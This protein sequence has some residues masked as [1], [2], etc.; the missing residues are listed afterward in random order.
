M[1][2]NIISLVSDW[3]ENGDRVKI[4]RFSA[5]IKGQFTELMFNESVDPIPSEEYLFHLRT[6]D[7]KNLIACLQKKKEQFKPLF[8]KILTSTLKMTKH[9]LPKTDLLYSLQQ[10]TNKTMA[11][12]DEH[13]QTVLIISDGLENSDYLRFHG[14]GDVKKVRLKR[15]IKKLKK[16][17]LIAKWNHADIYMYGLG[18]ISNTNAYIRPKLMEPLKKFWKV[19]F[20]EG[21]GKVKQLGTP[22]ILLSTIK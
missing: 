14:K 10:L 19:Y 11:Q 16:H 9:T 12:K 4:L 1:K 20:T 15:S 5:N 8:K 17:K 2:K 7:N 21:K 18:H 3:G 22:E 6:K 13:H